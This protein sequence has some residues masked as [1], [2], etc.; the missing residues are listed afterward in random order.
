MAVTCDRTLPCQVDD[1][2][3]Q[4]GDILH[5]AVTDTTT[6]RLAELFSGAPAPGAWTKGASSEGRRRG[7]GKVGRF[8][9]EDLAERGHDVLLLEKDADLV[10][11]LSASGR[12]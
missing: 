4:D 5:L 2:V 3:G 7:A 10:K 6:R 11:A 12:E 1:L 9:A 8:L